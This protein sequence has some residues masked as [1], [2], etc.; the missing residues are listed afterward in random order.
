[1]PVM[2]VIGLN[3]GS[4]LWNNALPVKGSKRQSYHTLS[5]QNDSLPSIQMVRGEYYLH[6]Q[7][8][9]VQIR[10]SGHPFHRT[11]GCFCA[12]LPL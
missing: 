2:S 5:L 12:F 10:I 8:N 3:I 7:S 6:H 9:L 1:M 11:M 4:D